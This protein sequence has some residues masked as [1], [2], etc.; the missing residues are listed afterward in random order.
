MHWILS[1]GE[2]PLTRQAEKEDCRRELAKEKTSCP[3][4]R[5]CTHERKMSTNNRPRTESFDLPTRRVEPVA[6]RRTAQSVR[7]V[8]P[9]SGYK[10]VAR[11]IVAHDRCRPDLPICVG[12]HL[13]I[14]SGLRTMEEKGEMARWR[15][16]ECNAENQMG[17][18]QH[19]S[20][21]GRTR[22]CVCVPV[23]AMRLPH[24]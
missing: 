9:Y 15:D 10:E 17:L 8:V 22:E 1:S 6:H 18:R 14:W 4:K 2:H 13:V 16:G 21:R 11:R 19:K 3:V 7:E 24:Q 5:L 12:I 23:C 20:E